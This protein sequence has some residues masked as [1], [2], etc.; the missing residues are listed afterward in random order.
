[1][2]APGRDIYEELI[3]DRRGT[4]TGLLFPGQGAQQVG[5]GRALVGAYPT[6]RRTFEEASDVVGFDLASIC[7]EGPADLLTS[8]R[9]CQPAVLTMSFAAWRVAQERGIT[10]AM[11]VGHSLGEY[12]ALVA[13]GSMSF[14]AA[15]T[16]VQ[17]RAE[18]TAKVA[19]R[20]PGAMVALLGARDD[21]VVAF[22]AK[23][24]DVWPANYNTPGQVV[25]SGLI[26]G[27]ERLVELAHAAGIKVRRLDVEGAFHSPVMAPAT[28]ELRAA[29]VEVP[30][31]APAVPFLS[32]TTAAFEDDPEQLR[33]LLARQ[34]TAPVYFSHSVSVALAAGADAFLELGP[35]RIL[36][37]LVRRIAPEVPVVHLGEPADLPAAL[38]LADDPAAG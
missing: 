32:A 26:A 16:L 21:D 37:G 27:V 38:A 13:C 20:R 7:F 8:T 10:A 23:A 29:L 17:A 25:A 33:A 9:V 6:A 14:A 22:C 35:R 1:M 19:A 4:R 18:A 28:D 31:A 11:A 34:L 3:T 12:T 5:M 24:G 30:I 15:L 2:E 36:A